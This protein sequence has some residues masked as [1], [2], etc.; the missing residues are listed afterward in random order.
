MPVLAQHVDPIPYGSH[1]G[2]ILPESVKEAG[3]VGVLLNHSEHPLHIIDI[4]ASVERARSLNLDAVV[5]ANNIGVTGAVAALK[6]HAVAI[7]PPDLIGGEV[8]VTTAEPHIVQNAVTAVKAI[9]PD[10]AVLCG[11]GVKTGGDVSAALK[12]GTAG[13]LLAS[14]VVKAARP[15]KVL[16]E[17]AEA[18]L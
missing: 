7:E 16:L 15:E 18:L 5:C 6:P 3:A 1:T 9:S 10:T 17:M 14:G 4:A 13:V 12:L 2:W 8:S 11:A